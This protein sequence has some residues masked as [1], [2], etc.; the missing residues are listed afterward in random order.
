M[1]EIPFV[2]VFRGGKSFLLLFLLATA[3]RTRITINIPLIDS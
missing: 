2:E 3:M 1:V